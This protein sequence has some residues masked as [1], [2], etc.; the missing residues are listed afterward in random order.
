MEK[1]SQVPTYFLRNKH[2]YWSYILFSSR[3]K[4]KINCLFL[5]Y[6]QSVFNVGGGDD[7]VSKTFPNNPTK[8]A[9]TLWAQSIKAFNE[10]P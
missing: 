8:I 9:M 2:F 4:K 5:L 6:L 7:D 10:A 1:S 3:K